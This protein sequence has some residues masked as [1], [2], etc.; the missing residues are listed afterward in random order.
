M[1]SPKLGINMLIWNTFVY[2]DG[3][4]KLIE[5]K[6]S[7]GR[8]NNG[9]YPVSATSTSDANT[10]PAGYKLFNIKGNITLLNYIW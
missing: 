2:R 6:N 7:M 1:N 8:K 5:A 9:W 3:D 10:E 4:L